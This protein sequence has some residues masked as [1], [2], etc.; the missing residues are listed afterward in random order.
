MPA[1][2]LAVRTRIAS[3]AGCFA[4]AVI[5]VACGGDDAGD[6][7]TYTSVSDMAQRLDD[8]GLRCV[9]EY[10]GLDDGNREV[11]LC[12]VNDEFTELSVWADASDAARTAA[13]ADDA[14]DPFVAGGNWTV[15]VDTANTAAAVA[16]A[17]GGTVHGT[18]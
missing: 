14:R 11:S 18:G 8:A 4:L 10:E 9:L 15:D 16:D 6:A 13:A 5:G 12:H 2:I 3:L 1:R 17:L 7:T